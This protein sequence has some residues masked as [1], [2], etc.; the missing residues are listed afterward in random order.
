M[1]LAVGADRAAKSVVEERAFARPATFDDRAMAQPAQRE[2]STKRSWT[3]SS[4]PG[5]GDASAIN[6]LARR[7]AENATNFEAALVQADA[8]RQ[9]LVSRR[10]SVEDFCRWGSMYCSTLVGHAAE[11]S[12]DV[13][14]GDSSK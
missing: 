4:D 12:N 14:I 2:A 5:L 13:G 1:R 8:R 11:G 7:L 9:L 6:N 10:Y 3:T